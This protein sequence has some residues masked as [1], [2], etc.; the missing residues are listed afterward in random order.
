MCS[1]GEEDFGDDGGA[2]TMPFDP[3][4]SSNSF[5]STEL[6]KK[7]NERNVVVKLNL[8]DA[9]CEECFY[10]FVRHKFRASMGATRI[11]ERGAK[12][13]LVFD[14][15]IE[16]CVMFDMVQY[17]LNLDRFK[18]LTI[19]PYAIYV[20]NTCM[21]EK[22]LDD[23]REYLK[24][25]IEI[26]N[27]FQIKTYYT[28]IADK[29][30]MIEIE[31]ALKFIDGPANRIAEKTFMD[32]FNAIGN[33][34]AKED[35]YS[36]TRSN[37]IRLASSKLDCKHVFV[38]TISHQIA[39]DILVN[40]AL[41]RGESVANN[42]SF[43]DNRSDCDSKILRPMRSI[44][45]L[46]IETYVRFNEQ[47]TKLIKGNDYVNDGW[48]I[49]NSDPNASIQNL[50]QNFIEN[51]QENF[52]ST[53]ST[54]YRTGDKISAAATTPSLKSTPVKLTCKFCHSNLDY[55]DS[56]TLLAIEYS[57]C[58][59][60]CVDQ[61]DVNDVDSMLNKAQDKLL[62]LNVSDNETENLMKFLCH[63]CRNIFRNLDNADDCIRLSCQ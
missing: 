23:R 36:L 12:V 38:S 24:Q 52:G 32:N 53:V 15:T 49:F 50:T 63:G 7:C 10:Y 31:N 46:E 2:H 25:T 61:N 37:L 57:R 62:G 18:R 33:Q 13:L 47:L 19:E 30:T 20:D 42:I 22:T 59:S 5:S 21:T 27:Y 35:F 34:T 8:K 55:E 6:C 60:A 54:V 14:G 1:I 29:T 39:A 11:V 43:C 56:A 58:V 17:A 26:L 40:V 4:I 41:G 16:S 9:Q 45:N 48:T 44:N 3:K 51:L 28:S